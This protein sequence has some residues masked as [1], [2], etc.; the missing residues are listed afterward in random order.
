MKHLKAGDHVYVRGTVIEMWPGECR[1]RLNFCGNRISW[2]II[3][4]EQDVMLRLPANRRDRKEKPMALREDQIA[5]IKI[6]YLAGTSIYETRKLAQCARDTVCRYFRAFR[7][8]GL[9]RGPRKPHK[10]QRVPRYEGPEMIGKRIA[11]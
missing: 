6:G 4:H 3:V 1:L 11:G 10:W 9:P 7:S 8:D 5:A 2:P